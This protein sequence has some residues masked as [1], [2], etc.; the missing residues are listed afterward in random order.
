MKINTDEIKAELH[1]IVSL[2]NIGSTSNAG[3][4]HLNELCDELMIM[5]MR[6]YDCVE[7]LELEHAQPAPVVVDK[8]KRKR[9]GG[10]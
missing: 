8:A 4:E 2:A 5:A 1:R 6:A 7:A 10:Q 3:G 9:K